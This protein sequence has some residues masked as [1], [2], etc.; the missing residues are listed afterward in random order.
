MKT[1]TKNPLNAAIGNSISALSEIKSADKNIAIFERSTSHLKNEV[2]TLISG[3]LT[4]QKSGSV[5]DIL[6]ELMVQSAA[7]GFSAPETLEDISDLLRS[8]EALTK[9]DSF[10]L[11]LETV[12][13]NMCRRFQTDLN[14]LRL[15]CTYSGPGTLWLPENNVNR[16]AL[17]SREENEAVFYDAEA[18]QQASAGD[19]LILKGALYP[20]ANTSAIVHRSPRIEESG[21]QRLLLRIDTNEF[22]NF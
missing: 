22:L 2:D 4:F 6:S 18:I 19:V 7:S 17:A 21:D 3:G 10:R 11:S 12:N 9:A 14:D 5:S 15:L 16:K 20:V 1:A 8:F 13:T